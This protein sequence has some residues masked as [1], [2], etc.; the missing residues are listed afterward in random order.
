N[1]TGQTINIQ[2]NQEDMQTVMTLSQQL[3]ELRIQKA[4]AK[5]NQQPGR[6]LPETENNL[7]RKINECKIKIDQLLDKIYLESE[8]KPQ[9]T[10]SVDPELEVLAGNSSNV[11]Q[12]L[13]YLQKKGV[14]DKIKIG[15][16]L[17]PCVRQAID[18]TCT[19]IQ[20]EPAREQ[21]Y[22]LNGA[23][24]EFYDYFTHFPAISSG[25]TIFF[26]TLAGKNIPLNIDLTQ[27]TLR[28]LYSLIFHQTGDNVVQ[29]ARIYFAGRDISSF[30]DRPLSMLGIQ[31]E[32]TIEHRILT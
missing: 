30:L 2:T 5:R 12:F 13:I 26:K 3:R 22:L 31:K 7:N 6:F 17:S 28:D 29:N 32:S 23:F 10:E 16:F 21:S 8:Q 15:S 18:T 11:L 19:D 24:A 14:S 27:S 9:T 25:A 20:S 1:R 4:V